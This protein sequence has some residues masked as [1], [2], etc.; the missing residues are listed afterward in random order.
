MADQVSIATLRPSITAED[1]VQ[2]AKL[3]TE[4]FSWA[5]VGEDEGNGFVFLLSVKWV[6]AWKEKVGYSV[7][8]D[9]VTLAPE[10]IK[11]EL[12]LPQVNSDLI[13]QEF[14]EQTEEY[15]FL[16]SDSPNYSLFA[17]I[18]KSDATEYIDYLL[19]KEDAWNILKN[20]YPDSLELKRV[21]VSD[22]YTGL[23]SVEVKF[24]MV[25]SSIILGTIILHS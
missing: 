19:I 10:H 9:G 16:K 24:P 18:V 17:S 12:E 2:E 11:M 6:E 23:S 7:V 25:S 5:Q 14:Q 20:K 13:D 15:E 8:E 21:K 4:M 22:V 1:W 3:F